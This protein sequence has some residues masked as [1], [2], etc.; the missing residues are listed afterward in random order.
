[1]KKFLPQFKNEYAENNINY[2][3]ANREYEAP[4]YQFI[5]EIF[6]SLE[7]TGYITMI[8]WHLYDDES[9]FDI[10]KFNLTRKKKVKNKK[11]KSKIINIDYD[12]VSLLYM[13]FNIRVKNES[14]FKEVYLLIPK[15][16]DNNFLYIKGK[17]VY[18]IYQMVNS[19]TYVTK[20]SVTLK[21]LMPLCINRES[22]EITDTE[23]IIYKVPYYRILNFNKKFN[24]MNIFCAKFGLAK[25][26]DMFDCSR[27]LTVVDAKEKEDYDFIYFQIYNTTQVSKNIKPANIKVKVLKRLF[28]K[29]NYLKGITTMLVN[30]LNDAHKP[31]LINIYENSDYW[32]GVL[33]SV[34]TND[35][36]INTDI[37]RS[38]LI[39]FERLIDLTTKRLL[40]FHEINK[41]NVY[42]IIVTL[43]QNFDEFKKKNNNDV[44]NRR[45]RLNEC[46]GSLTSQQL[47]RSVGR[48]MKKGEK[49]TLDNVVGILKIPPN[50]IFRTLY[51][52]SLITFNDIIND[53]DFFNAF[54]FSIR[55]PNSI[56]SKSER[57]IT[58]KDRGVAISSI[59]IVDSDVCSSSSPGLGGLISPYA[60]T[61]G[62]YFSD[63]MEPEDGVYDFIREA[64][65]Y[66]DK[67]Q[68]H[69]KLPVTYE[70]YIKLKE[71]WAARHNA[72]LSIIRNEN[73]PIYI[74]LRD[75][76][77][78]SAYIVRFGEVKKK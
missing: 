73:D 65:Q 48:I 49:V 54:K 60:K 39:F 40:R 63:E 51:S 41:S 45:L 59:G 52:S 46:I 7:S 1:M 22:V 21:G 76:N 69:I 28:V 55:G 26:I 4:L 35:H 38:S 27:V 14:T 61:Y 5:L 68:P 67:S 9:K 64:Y 6:Q 17:K 44:R 3:L 70:E 37:G 75:E 18:L 33:G 78:E 16:D 74:Y 57:K 32:L 34:Y 71:E 72:I 11:D 2:A 66:V 20:N 24:P 25:T 23:G 15:F 12:R 47:G 8:D 10:S 31:D 30:L 56:G 43:I 19:S 53:M 62:L 13:R 36:S 42:N 58:A 77:K 29:Y 50:M